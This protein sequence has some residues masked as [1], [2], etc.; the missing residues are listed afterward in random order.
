MKAT[1]AVALMERGLQEA[2]FEKYL[3]TIYSEIRKRAI[4]GDK[5]LKYNY[6]TYDQFPSDGMREGIRAKLQRDGFDVR[7]SDGA[8]YYQKYELIS[9]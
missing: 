4:M 8:Y 5:C 9:W 6:F 3:E 1:E 2:G 7:K